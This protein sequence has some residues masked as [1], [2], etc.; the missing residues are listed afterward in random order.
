MK[1]QVAILLLAVMILSICTVGCGQKPAA[2]GKTQSQASILEKVVST[3]KL[4]VGILPDFAPWASR[5]SQGEFEGYDVDIAMRLGEALGVEVELIPIEA[6]NRVPSLVSD[7]VDVLIA[8]LTPTDE[9][10]KTITFTIPYASAGLI[11]MVWADD[12]EIKTYK[13]L[14]GK[15][16]ALVRGGA[17]DFGT[18][19]MI[20]DAEI[21]RFDTIADAFTAFQTKK[22]DAFVEED[23]FVFYQCK[24]DPQFKAVGEPFSRELISL[25]IK[26]GDQEWL[27]YL[28]NF[29]INLRFTGE[30]AELYKKWFGYEPAPL[31]LN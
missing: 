6:P 12:N 26:K 21:I 14:A 3:K 7:K 19:K 1:K 27:N 10:A 15:K 4:R 18:S 28:N 17:P 30:N 9:R 2:D 20:P 22:A 29:L 24:Q 23:T 13:D 5:N 25:S 8:C 11:P 16:V 31:T